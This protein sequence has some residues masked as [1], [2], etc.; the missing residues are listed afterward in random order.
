MKIYNLRSWYKCKMMYKTAT[1]PLII[2]QIRDD[3][4]TGWIGMR[5][6]DKTVTGVMVI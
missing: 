1:C 2:S 5:D 6:S 4:G 3:W